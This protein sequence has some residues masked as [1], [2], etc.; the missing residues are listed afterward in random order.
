MA[1]TQTT[2]F[3]VREEIVQIP[4]PPT[5]PVTP[6]LGPYDYENPKRKYRRSSNGPHTAGK[7]DT[8]PSN[9]MK[10][11]ITAIPRDRTV[12][13]SPFERIKIE[14]DRTTA[15]GHP[16]ILPTE[17]GVHGP[18]FDVVAL[19]HNAVKRQVLAT[20]NMLEAM[21]RYKYE[22]TSAITDAFFNWFDTFENAVD[23]I[24]ELEEATIFP[25]LS[26]RSV[27]IPPS[28]S[29]AER[30]KMK[31]T[32]SLKIEQMDEM[33]STL[34]LL[35][36]GE[37]VLKTSHFLY[38]LLKHVISY[39]NMQS[40]VLPKAIADANISK[41]YDFQ[42]GAAI[43]REVKVREDPAFFFSFLTHWMSQKQLKRWKS[44][45]LTTLDS[46]RFEQW[47]RKSQSNHF[48]VPEKL[49]NK[50]SVRHV[51]D[52]SSPPSSLGST[53]FSRKTKQ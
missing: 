15:H 18:I 49:I 41:V 42:L 45:Y 24:F 8:K 39:F 28:I 40:L 47:S 17:Y 52:I 35:P 9:S 48:S 29:E 10:R 20:Y 26:A 34:T 32:Y 1:G 6:S 21:L 16:V 37:C 23:T 25:F 14:K 36:P 11:S 43:A 31:G 12:P 44:R 38:D 2:Q 30:R 50:V 27:V 22:V 4:N 51:D 33:R 3:P 13:L 53:F 5:S 46:F 19:Y 7:N